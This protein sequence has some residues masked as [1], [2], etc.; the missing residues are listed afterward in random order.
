MTDEKDSE[1]DVSSA[2]DTK[3]HP[4]AD[5]DGDEAPDTASGGPA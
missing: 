4:V 2:P 1:G 3:G 5:T